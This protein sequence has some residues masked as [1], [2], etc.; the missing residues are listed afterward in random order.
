[1]HVARFS[2]FRVK[3]RGIKQQQHQAL[4]RE[5]TNMVTV[6]LVVLHEKGSHRSRAL[7]DYGRGFTPSMP[8]ALALSTRN[9]SHGHIMIH[10]R[11]GNKA[12]MVNGRSCATTNLKRT[13]G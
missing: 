8:H 10:M 13:G 6:L 12:A 5:R 3:R 1:M 4:R 7:Q 11:W 9:S 2:G